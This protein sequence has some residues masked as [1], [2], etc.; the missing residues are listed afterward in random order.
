MPCMSSR[1]LWSWYRPVFLIHGKPYS[2]LFGISRVSSLRNLLFFPGNML[3]ASYY[4]LY[5]FILS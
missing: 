4:L 1:K 2:S 5:K 3:Q